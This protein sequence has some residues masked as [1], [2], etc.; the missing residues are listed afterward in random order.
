MCYCGVCEVRNRGKL[1]YTLP[2]NTV[3]WKVFKDIFIHRYKC[4][5][6]SVKTCQMSITQIGNPSLYACNVRQKENENEP[7]NTTDSLDA[8][9][10][11]GK[12][13][14]VSGNWQVVPRLPLCGVRE[15][16]ADTSHSG[17]PLEGSRGQAF[18]C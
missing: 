14:L 3:L 8:S 12:R 9:I 7:F 18:V 6:I 2:N 13:C 10:L 11:A 15:R 5:K 4:K 1:L 17:S 16:K